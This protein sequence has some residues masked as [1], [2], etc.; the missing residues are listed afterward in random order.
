MNSS[1]EAPYVSEGVSPWWLKGLAIFMALI[2][3][4]MLLSVASGLLTPI[5]LDRLMPEDFEEVQ[6][7]PEDG[8]D[9]EKAEWNETNEFWD[10]MVEYMDEMMRVMKFQAVHSGI[11]AI[12][13]LFSVPVLWRG[14]RDLGI[15]LVG[16][17]IGV[18]LLGG[19]GLMWMLTRSGLLMPEFATG[20]GGEEWGASAEL[21]ETITLVASWGQI[22]FCN[23]CFLGIL[24]L[25]A[26]KSKPPT[27]L[28]SAPVS[29]ATIP[30]QS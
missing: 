6:P 5:F 14:D 22:I 3:I 25:V 20:R 28:V 13:G 19:M 24:G 8:T 17:W 15:K 29:D 18:N 30:P 21:M 23:I 2:S 10:D 11:L 1:F 16:V 4:F 7:Y 27:R 26:N 9:E 12:I